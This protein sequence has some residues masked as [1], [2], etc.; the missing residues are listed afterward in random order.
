MNWFSIENMKIFEKDLAK[1]TLEQTLPVLVGYFFLG[2][3]FGILLEKSGYGV[4]EC[5]F[6]SVFIFSGSMQYA[7]IGLL[8]GGVSLFTAFMSTI[9]IN[10]RYF[11]YSLSLVGKYQNTGWRK[12]YLIHSI[13]DEAYAI[14]SEN[15]APEG[16]EEAD[17]WL[18]VSLYDHCYWIVSTIIGVLLGRMIP[19]ELKGIDFVM[20]ALFVTI[21]VEQWLKSDDHLPA[22]MGIVI[23]IVCLEFF[24]HEHFLWISMIVLSI[25]CVFYKDKERGTS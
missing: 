11:F 6:M 19:L 1:Y 15:D 24:G 12:P 10:A 3:G 4:L 7:I 18:A 21:F 22:L 2:I 17:Y 23:P 25:C 8:D 13:V 5:I 20:T 14:I 9:I 16:Y